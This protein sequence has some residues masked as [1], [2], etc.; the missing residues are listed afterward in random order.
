MQPAQH[1]DEV[2]HSIDNDLHAGRVLVRL[3]DPGGKLI[4]RRE[5]VV[6]LAVRDLA[7]KE[8]ERLCDLVGT[9]RLEQ[10]LR[11]TVGVNEG[12][13]LLCVDLR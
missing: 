2:P 12:I 1:R 13:V 3:A 11:L 7:R 5:L 4:Q 9:R 6:S 8:P 10:F